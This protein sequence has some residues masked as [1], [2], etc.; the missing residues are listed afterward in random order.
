MSNDSP[1]P[2]KDVSSER[3]ADLVEHFSGALTD[4]VLTAPTDG[5]HAMA[6]AESVCY[7]TDA[8]TA[9]KELQQ[10]RGSAHEPFEPQTAIALIADDAYAA[11]FQTMAQYRSALLSALPSPPPEAKCEWGHDEGDGLWHTGCGEI[12]VFFSGGPTDNKHKFC[13]YCRK[14]IDDLSQPAPTKA[15]E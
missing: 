15:G 2:S 10:L 7:V 4:M 14:G 9:L 8:V 11:T 13:P 12:H 6:L 3:L 5:E 1:L